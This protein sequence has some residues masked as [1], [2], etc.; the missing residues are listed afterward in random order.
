MSIRPLP[1]DAVDK[2]KSASAISS[3]NQV[4]CGLLKN[5]LDAR[6]SKVNLHLDY[7]LGNCVVE[8]NGDGI[9]PFEFLEDGGLLKLHRE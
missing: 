8:D 6:S 5:S 4:A 3:L 2:I 7:L 1:Q 9:E